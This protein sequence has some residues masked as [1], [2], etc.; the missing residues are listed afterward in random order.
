ML[1]IE[2]AFSLIRSES[3]SQNEGSYVFD[4][5]VPMILVA[6]KICQLGSHSLL[7]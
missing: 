6:L 7:K 4:I 3:K 1:I 2:T 5:N